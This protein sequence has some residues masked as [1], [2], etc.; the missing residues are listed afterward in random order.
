VNVIVEVSKVKATLKLGA[1]VTLYGIAVSADSLNK[2]FKLS[3]ENNK[4]IFKNANGNDVSQAIF[5]VTPPE[6]G[7]QE[8]ILD[9]IDEGV[10]K[11]ALL[12]CP[13]EQ[14]SLSVLAGLAAELGLNASAVVAPLLAAAQG[15]AQG[16][17]GLGGLL[18][19]DGGKDGKGGKGKGRP[20]CPA[21]VADRKNIANVV[22][23]LPDGESRFTEGINQEV[24]RKMGDRLSWWD[25]DLGRCTF[26]IHQRIKGSNH[27]Q[28]CL[29][30]KPPG[31]PELNGKVLPGVINAD[32]VQAKVYDHDHGILGCRWVWNATTE[33]G[34]L[35]VEEGVSG[36]LALAH[37]TDEMPRLTRWPCEG[38]PIPPGFPALTKAWNNEA[39]CNNY[40]MIVRPP[41]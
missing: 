11:A 15:G 31:H 23:Q 30:Y 38:G 39:K 41:A 33:H 13:P 32:L 40:C 18:P 9:K 21:D 29:N 20:K 27:E 12:I 37:D 8:V 14:V 6:E 10:T 34:G 4:Q 25:E 1:P 26:P 16:V 7:V 35:P 36:C 17:E 24:C 22:R 2:A 5:F 28:F 19:E 3:T